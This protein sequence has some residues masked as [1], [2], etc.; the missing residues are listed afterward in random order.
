MINEIKKIK[1]VDDFNGLACEIFEGFILSFSKENGLIRDIE[2]SD[3]VEDTWEFVYTER[4][5]KLV[6]RMRSR[7]VKVGQKYFPDEYIEVESF[8]YQEM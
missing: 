6:K 5:M 2:E 4:G 8:F 7:L 3:I 1:T